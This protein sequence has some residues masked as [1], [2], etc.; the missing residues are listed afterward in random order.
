MECLSKCQET[1]GCEW[2]SFQNS[3]QTCFLLQNCPTLNEELDDFTSGQ[4][5]CQL[6]PDNDYSKSHT[7][8]KVKY[9]S[10][11][12]ILTKPQH[13]HEFFTQIFCWQFFSWNQSWKQ[14]KSPKPKHFHEF[15]TQI[16]C[17][18]FFSWNQSCQQLKSPKPQHFHEFS[19]FN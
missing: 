3:K 1:K 7:I 16:F 11:N 17:W 14:I 15:F 19:F 13:F 18:Q 9:L 4:K 6:S 8:R 5:S 12:S 2:Y 10:K